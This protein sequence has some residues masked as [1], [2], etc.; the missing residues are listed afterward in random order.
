MKVVDVRINGMVNP[1]GFAYPKV[2]CSWK[3]TEA[4]SKR[5][6]NVKICIYEDENCSKVLYVKEGRDLQSIGEVLE[7][8]LAPRTRYYVRV[9][10]TGENAE[11]ARSEVAYFET[12]KMQESWTADF[13]GMQNEDTFH[14]VFFKKFVSEKVVKSAHIYVSGLG[15]YEAYLNGTK[16]GQDFLA[17]FCND[18]HEHIQYQTYDVTELV[19]GENCLEIM[20]GNGWYKGRLGY[21]GDAQYYGNRFWAIAE[22]HLTYED[23]TTTQIVTDESWQ[24]RGSDIEMSD[25][26]DGECYNRLLWEKKE[27]P[28]KTVIVL[29][30]AVASE[31]EE[32]GVRI[33]KKELLIERYSLPVIVKEELAV[34][35]IIHTPAG[36][37]VLDMGQNFT[38]YI[39]FKANL[40][41]GTTVVF[42]FGEILQQGNFYN[43][44]YRTAKSRFVYVANGDE[45]I[46]RPHFTYFGF[47]YVRLN[48]WVG[49]MDE[50]D[51][52]GKVVYS[53]LSDT[54]T[55]ESSSKL[56]NQLA[57]NCMW[58]QRSNF[59]DMPTDCPQRDERLGWTGDA[60]VFAPT[61]CFNMDTRAFYRKYL[62][63][64]HLDQL[65]HDGQIANYIPNLSHMPG[66]S[67]VWGDVATFLPMALYQYYGDKDELENHYPMMKDWVDSIIRQDKERG[68][69]HLWN[70]GFHFG[71]WLAM[72]G[73]TQQSM[74]GG[75]DDYF[76]A[77]VYYYA[78]T[79]KVAKA[80]G[81]LGKQEDMETYRAKAELIYQAILDEYFSPNGRLTIDTQTGY[82]ISLKFGVY[83]QKER[84]LEGLKTRL[85]KD[86][87]KIK[88]GFVGATMM[89]Q[90]LAEH[91]LEDMA[92][93]I[94]FQE[95]FPGW[96]HCI[97]LG[98][99][100]IW[101][102]WNS[103]LDDGSISGTGMNSLNHYSYGS[104][105]E[106][107]YRYIVGMNEMTPGFT[108]VRFVP[109]L[110][111]KLEYVNCAYESVSGTYV[112]NWRIHKDGSI[113]VHFEVPFGCSAVALL[114]GTGGE[115]VKLEAGVFERTY[116]PKTDYRKLY[117]MDSRL[118]E[119]Q[120]DERA[121]EILRTELPIAYGLIMSQDAENLSLSLAE[122]QF[123]FFMGFNPPMV[124]N[125]AAKIMELDA[126][127]CNA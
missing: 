68:E 60:Q 44:N 32:K 120:K 78:S 25:I 37:T 122:M 47:R 16:I 103:V 82:L 91:G 14:P 40:P 119:F 7:V 111:A 41:K 61:A 51:F 75:T 88:G 108:A 74:K 102:R 50:K 20:T 26:Y 46:V 113:T 99:T 62:Y 117:S 109:Q 112:S 10:V 34:K 4:V 24:Y 56:L 38:G 69:Q 110:N 118:E 73:V 84:V 48:G 29:T 126:M 5:Q 95:G 11:S 79:L 22:L 3:V 28:A 81:I 30:E 57:N 80:A 85:K 71:D 2:K 76:V 21:E 123:M 94:L 90:V 65:K 86:C 13:I 27:N 107:V 127:W 23:G 114:P 35:E 17:P 54:I 125:A 121:M 45:E 98:A 67:S 87:Y 9:E 116:Q 59:L 89:C 18:Y 8:S 106:Y 49:E 33:P 43:E 66:G 92:Y 42:D 97:Q 104:V 55:F 96:M 93:H 64:L 15:L 83:I 12:G 6:T 72:D 105:M 52:V 1:V 115:E 31:L 101:E 58:G 70:F 77:S 19:S 124:Q 63:D 53:D 39:E 100:T 36:E